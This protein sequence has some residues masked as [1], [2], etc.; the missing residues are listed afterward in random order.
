MPKGKPFFQYLDE[1]AVDTKIA[2]SEPPDPD[3]PPDP[4]AP[5]P[6][7]IPYFI[8]LQEKNKE[9]ASLFA[10]NGILASQYDAYT[11]AI[12]DGKTGK[13][14]R[15]LATA[16]YPLQEIAYGLLTMIKAS[17]YA[18]AVEGTP[19]SV[20]VKTV[21][22]VREYNAEHTDESPYPPIEEDEA[23]PIPDDTPYLLF[24]IPPGKDGK[25]G[26][27]GQDGEPGEPGEPGQPG[28]DGA[29][30][31]DCNGP[32]SGTGGG[33]NGGQGGSGP[34]GAPNPDGGD[35]V[36][37]LGNCNDP[38]INFPYC[39][40]SFT[41]DNADLRA[42]IVDVATS[43]GHYN[44]ATDELISCVLD[45][46]GAAYAGVVTLNVDVGEDQLG[47]SN[48]ATVLTLTDALDAVQNVPH[49]I[50][51]FGDEEVLTVR[52]YHYSGSLGVALKP[53]D[54]PI[55]LD[56]IM[57]TYPLGGTN[58]CHN[59]PDAT[60]PAWLKVCLLQFV[61]HTVPGPCAIF[62]ITQDFAQG[63]YPYW[64]NGHGNVPHIDQWSGGYPVVQE[65]AFPMVYAGPWSV[66]VDT[67]LSEVPVTFDVG[68]WTGNPYDI[69]L[70]EFNSPDGTMGDPNQ[71]GGTQVALATGVHIDTE[72]HTYTAVWS[73]G[74]DY[75][76]K[77]GKCY[78]ANLAW[79]GSRGFA[80]GISVG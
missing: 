49:T 9:A 40:D 46:H 2:S 34:G 69:K 35:K 60:D 12:S 66:P 75:V 6:Q 30:C 7:K 4:D 21:G 52:G 22:Y 70:F 78:T 32:T 57:S 61:K 31:T 29:D 43:S 26:L 28:Q 79:S 5:I 54:K 59:P 10:H 71:Y 74:G 41:F 27:D 39:S 56:G 73:E 53:A 65:N 51:D 77:A 18:V 17:F 36:V 16:D 19:V 45:F 14:A 63:N 50:E 33:P 42:A 38:I 62:P 23:D 24:T 1:L 13:E 80:Y 3:N 8:T 68:I 20:E 37:Y 72:R 48:Y 11:R 55:S 67:P 15:L 47:G 76:L 25:D 44:P 58:F 64:P